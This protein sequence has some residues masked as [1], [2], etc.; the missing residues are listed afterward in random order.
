M[1]DGFK[2]PTSTHWHLIL[3]ARVREG[4]ALSRKVGKRSVNLG[5]TA[6]NATTYAPSRQVSIGRIRNTYPVV[7]ILLLV[8]WVY[9]GGSHTR[10]ADTD[11]GYM[12]L[13]GSKPGLPPKK[14]GEPI[15]SEIN[16]P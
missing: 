13:P 9:P 12:I 7:L 5:P 10:L 6:Y 2:K 3:W 8:S 11:K 4:T 1:G 16:K 15:R 14:H